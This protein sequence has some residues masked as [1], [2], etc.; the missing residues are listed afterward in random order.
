MISSRS[1]LSQGSVGK[2]EQGVRGDL[3]NAQ[4]HQFPSG[5][6]DL[7][8]PVGL[9]RQ[10]E[11]HVHIHTLETR[12]DARPYSFFDPVDGV[13]PAE[14]FQVPVE[15]RL[16]A[17]AQMLHPQG[18]DLAQIV[19]AQVVGMAFHVDV[20]LQIER[21][22]QMCPIISPRPLSSIVVGV[23]PPMYK[24]VMGSAAYDVR[25]EVHFR[26]DR[27]DVSLARSFRYSSLL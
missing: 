4:L 19:G 24:E 25:I 3:V 6:F 10:G 20:A 5:L 13:R 26:L 27:V 18:L 22:A 15:Q 1:P 23:P 14:E 11:H 8:L 7:D 17:D 9:S 12:G 21:L 2:A 16:D